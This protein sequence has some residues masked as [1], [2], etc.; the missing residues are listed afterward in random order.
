MKIRIS[1]KNCENVPHNV[2]ISYKCDD[3]KV[4]KRTGTYF[5]E[6]RVL[7]NFMT[8]YLPE[9]VQNSRNLR[10]LMFTEINAR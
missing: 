2:R 8:T 9:F 1:F 4:G 6:C 10:K 7:T 5:W 3:L